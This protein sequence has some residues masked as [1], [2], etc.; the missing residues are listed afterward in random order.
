MRTKKLDLDSAI[1]TAKQQLDA[2]P[3]PRDASS[4]NERAR[5]AEARRVGEARH[6]ELWNGRE[7]LFDF[8]RRLKEL[9][10]DRDVWLD[11]LAELRERLALTKDDHLH[12]EL[13]RSIDL[14]DR[15]VCEDPDRAGVPCGATV[16]V[17]LGNRLCGVCGSTEIR[18]PAWETIGFPPQPVVPPPLWDAVSKRS[19]WATLRPLHY[20]LGRIADEEAERKAVVARVTGV[21]RALGIE[22]SEAA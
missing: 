13:Q 8:D 12:D 6:M 10:R 18:W 1:A 14:I 22:T 2:I 17:S 4:L 7:R 3:D 21:L 19:N 11:V 9:H 15:G 5:R 16:S 20:L